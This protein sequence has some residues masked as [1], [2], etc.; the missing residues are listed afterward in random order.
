[1]SSKRAD[2]AS[3]RSKRTSDGRYLIQVIDKSRSALNR[4][5]GPTYPIP[6]NPRA[7]CDRIASFLAPEKRY[8]KVVVHWDNG[9]VQ[10]LDNQISME[11]LIRHA[12]FLEVKE[13][14]SVH[15][16]A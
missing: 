2:A 13:I 10:R 3:R 14:K 1:M 4:E 12:E 8:A 16:A 11:D 9:R 5:N 7:S 6:F 15:W